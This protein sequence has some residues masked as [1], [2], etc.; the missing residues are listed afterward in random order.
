[1]PIKSLILRCTDGLLAKYRG[2][3][4]LQKRRKITGVNFVKLGG[5]S[6]FSRT[7]H[8]AG[9]RYTNISKVYCTAIII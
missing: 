7:V 3:V 6:V 5:N 1:M 2:N 8:S 9:S 4:E